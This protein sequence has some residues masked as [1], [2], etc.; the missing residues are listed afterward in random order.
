[1]YT[2]YE[3]LWHCLKV[4]WSIVDRT[5]ITLP[6]SIYR[7]EIWKFEEI[8]V[9]ILNVFVKTAWEVEGY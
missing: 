8:E 9:D 1:M 7:Y 2:L 6:S 5:C 4:V 3:I